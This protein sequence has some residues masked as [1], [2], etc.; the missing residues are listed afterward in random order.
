MKRFHV[1]VVV[2]NLET[3]IGFYSALFGATPAKR[4]AD[5]AKWMLEDPRM[6]FA[7][8]TRGTKTG[9]DHFGLEVDSDEELDMLR[10]QM[11]EP[12]L[13]PIFDE[14][15]TTCCYAMSDKSWTLDPNGIAWETYHTMADAELFNAPAKADPACCASGVTT[16]ESTKAGCC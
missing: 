9:V 5:Y 16:G 15:K 10:K 4:K 8:S 13:L 6:N 7:I 3:S 1:H 2:E 11:K 14:G 12:E